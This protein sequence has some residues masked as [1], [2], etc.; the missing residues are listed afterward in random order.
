MAPHLLLAL[1]TCDHD[2]ESQQKSGFEQVRNVMVKFESAWAHLEAVFAKTRFISYPENY[3]PD[4]YFHYASQREDISF[5]KQAE[6]LYFE[7]IREWLEN[8]S[9]K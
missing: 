5:M 8:N 4:R 9:V 7:M 2:D 3:V 1:Q 6:D